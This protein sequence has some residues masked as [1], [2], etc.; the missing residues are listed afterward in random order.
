M[1]QSAYNITPNVVTYNSLLKV[2]ASAA[3]RGFSNLQEARKVRGLGR[4]LGLVQGVFTR[5]FHPMD[6]AR[7]RKS[8]GW[9]SAPIGLSLN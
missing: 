1:M 4:G 9:G 8:A 6:G 3:G 2:V 5:T 7:P